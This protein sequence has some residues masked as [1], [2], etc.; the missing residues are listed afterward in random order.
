[1]D[2]RSWLKENWF[3]IALLIVVIIGFFYFTGGETWIGFYYPDENNLT[4]HTQSAELETIEEC[5][6]WVESQ[7]AI[8][9]PSGFGYDYECGKNCNFDAGIYVCEETIR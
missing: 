3:K 9:N 4:E 6:F 7:I 5:R 8:H 1:M 2:K